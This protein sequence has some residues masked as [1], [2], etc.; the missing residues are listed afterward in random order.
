MERKQ[1]ADAGLPFFGLTI[2]W[3]VPVVEGAINADADAVMCAYNK[4]NRVYPCNNSE[5][6]N[7]RPAQPVEIHRLGDDRLGASHD[8]STLQARL[9]VEA[10]NTLQLRLFQK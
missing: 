4:M 8:L 7:Q 6:L 3:V 5:L 2:H 10:P 9:E 1:T